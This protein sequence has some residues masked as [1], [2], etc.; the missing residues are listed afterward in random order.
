MSSA[1]FACNGY[2]LA[3]IEELVNG[4]DVVLLGSDLLEL[5]ARAMD[6]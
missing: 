6:S 2:M 4:H 3:S 1:W 5:S